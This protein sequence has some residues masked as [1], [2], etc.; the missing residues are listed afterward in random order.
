[1][2]HVQRAGDVRRRQHD[3]VGFAVPPGGAKAPGRFPT[4]VDPALDVAGGIGLVHEGAGLYGKGKWGHSSFASKWGQTSVVDA[5]VRGSM[6]PW[7]SVADAEN[8]KA[9]APAM[10]VAP[11]APFDDCDGQDLW[12]PAVPAGNLGNARVMRWRCAG[13]GI[14]CRLS[15][16]R[17]GRTP[18]PLS[19]SRV[20][21][22]C[23]S[24]RSQSL[25]GLIEPRTD[26]PT[27]AASPRLLARA[28]CPHSRWLGKSREIRCLAIFSNSR[29]RWARSHLL[30]AGTELK[31]SASPRSSPHQLCPHFLRAGPRGSRRTAL[32]RDRSR[33]RSHRESCRRAPRTNS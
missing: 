7:L 22:P 24:P 4:L 5:P 9:V 30:A 17:S 12:T 19:P 25:R 16:L 20:H 18:R 15:S 26:A 1:M 14:A 28:A 11:A 8:G 13:W 3:A 29:R 10:G 31:T 33:C 6:S 2:A 27:A 21:R 23:R 32:P